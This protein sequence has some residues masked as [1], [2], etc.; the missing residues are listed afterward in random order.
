MSPDRSD[1]PRA[2]EPARREAA[3]RASDADRDAVLVRLHTAFAEG[4]L[5]EAEL[6]ERIAR[7]LESRTRGELTAVVADIP[8]TAGPRTVATAPAGRAGRFHLAYKDSLHR[9]GQWALPEKSTVVVYK[10]TGLLDLTSAEFAGPVTRLRVVAYK[11]GVDVI[12]PPGV[13]VEAGGIGVSSDVRDPA[14]AGA[15]VL[16]VD[17]VGYKGSIDV[18]DHS[19]PR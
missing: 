7:T 19:S 12:V 15:P 9:S 5:D 16:R 8:A 1:A 17:G 4:R 14:P 6:D 10:G 2:G 3:E 13:R 18:K 11:S